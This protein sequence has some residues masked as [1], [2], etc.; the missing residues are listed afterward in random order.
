MPHLALHQGYLGHTSCFIDEANLET[1]LKLKQ[2][3]AADLGQSGSGVYSQ[4][5]QIGSEGIWVASLAG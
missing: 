5:K 3:E 4:A 2:E 1:L